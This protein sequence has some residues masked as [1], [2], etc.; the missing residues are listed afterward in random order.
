MV[1][2]ALPLEERRVLA[3]SLW[4][5]LSAFT[6]LLFS[7]VAALSG[8]TQPLLTGMILAA[9]LAAALLAA[10]GL[11]WR[12]YRAWNRRLVWPAARLVVRLVTAICYFVSIAAVGRAGSRLSRTG[13]APGVSGWTTRGPL[14]RESYGATYAGAAFAKGRRGWISDY[15]L[16]ARRTGNLWAISLLPFLLILRTLPDERETDAPPNIYTLF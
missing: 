15:V 11:A 13:S 6:A 4:F 12:I 9:L 14:A 7:A 16:W 10:P 8:V 1:T 2:I 3:R 5:T